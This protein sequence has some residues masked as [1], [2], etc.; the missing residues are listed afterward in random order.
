MP[1]YNDN[2]VTI[3]SG[4]CRVRIDRRVECTNWEN[5]E[6]QCPRNS[7]CYDDFFRQCYHKK[8]GV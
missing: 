5:E 1:K 6:K 3:F 7:C 8:K 4:L 2:K